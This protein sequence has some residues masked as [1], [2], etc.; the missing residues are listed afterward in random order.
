[1]KSLYSWLP[2]LTAALAAQAMLATGANAEEPTGVWIDHTGRGAVEITSCNGK[3]CGQ[4]VWLLD[5]KNSKACGIQIL[6][7]VP[8]K[9]PGV[10]DGGWIYDPEEKSKYDV[11]I[12][13]VGADKLKILGYA[14][15]KLFGQTMY[16]T[17][18]P[19]NL[20]RCKA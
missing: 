7:N 2:S 5:A 15:I 1:M 16:W 20:P 3:L 8:P 11:E 10:W 19:A 12:R 6:A 18:A 13:T 17:R 4:V 9:G 14:G